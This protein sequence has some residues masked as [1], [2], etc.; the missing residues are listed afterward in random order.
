MEFFTNPHYQ[1]IQAFYSDS[2]AKRSGVLYIQHIN[3]GL[4]VLDAIQA[5][6]SAHEAYCLH[7]IVQGDRE[8]SAAFQPTSVLH[9]YPINHYA[10]ALVMEYRWVANSY[11][12][13]RTI[14]S[15]D[16]IKLSPLVEVQQMLIADKIQNRKD[17]ERHHRDTHPR[18]HELDRYFRNWLKVLGITETRYQ[19]LTRRIDDVYPSAQ[20]CG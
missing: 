7:P 2:R 12:S 9:Q 11:L 8:L 13:Q 6:R 1:A 17:F 14:Q 15:I 3:E 20:Q 4:L 10:L 5:T 16:E 19:E 18:A